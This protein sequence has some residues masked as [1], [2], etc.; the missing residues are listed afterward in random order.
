[1]WTAYIVLFVCIMHFIIVY[2][3]EKKVTYNIWTYIA[4]SVAIASNTK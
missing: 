4:I 2:S 1:M 3:E